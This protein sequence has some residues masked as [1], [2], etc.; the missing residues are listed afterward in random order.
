MLLTRKARVPDDAAPRSRLT[1]GLAGRF[2]QKTVDRRGFL[3]GSGMTAG[4][5]AMASQLPFGMIGKA[6]FPEA[7]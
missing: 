4:A 5:A 3:K 1:R 6:T 2:D 7:K